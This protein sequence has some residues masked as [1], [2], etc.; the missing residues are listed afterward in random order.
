[1]IDLK[2][3]LGLEYEKPYNCFTLVKEVR[4]KM[5]LDT[6]T[7][8]KPDLKENMS[9][10]RDHAHSGLWYKRT[11]IY[12]GLLGDVVL[13]SR[14]RQVTAH[15]MGVMVDAES[16]IHIDYM[17]TVALLA[18]SRIAIAYPGESSRWGTSMYPSNFNSDPEE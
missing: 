4:K 9:Q 5:G 12:T 10:I 8:Y 6:P 1:M 2:E 3:F 15:H 11:S 7:L 16:L 14:N 13:L 18:L 17:R